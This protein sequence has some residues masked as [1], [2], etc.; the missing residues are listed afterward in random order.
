MTYIGQRAK[1]EKYF[2]GNILMLLIMAVTSLNK[3]QG[4]MDHATLNKD[5]IKL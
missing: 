5:N 3:D 4:F 1:M 2:N